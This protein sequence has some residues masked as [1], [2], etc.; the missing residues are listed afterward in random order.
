MVDLPRTCLVILWPLATLLIWMVV[1]KGL[2]RV[3]PGG[4]QVPVWCMPRSIRGQIALLS[5]V[6][7]VL[8]LLAAGLGMYLMGQGGDDLYALASGP[9]SMAV[10]RAAARQPFRGVAWPGYPHLIVALGLAELVALAAWGAWKVAGGLLRPMESV[11]AELA[12]LDFGDLPAHVPEPENA[13]EVTR[14]GD[15][16]NTCLSRLTQAKEELEEVSCR[17][18]RFASDVSHELRNPVAALRAELEDAQLDPARAR[19]PDLLRSSLRQVVRLQAIIDDL[20]WLSRVRARGSAERQRLDLAALVRTEISQ[21]ADRLPVLVDLTLGATVAAVPSQIGRLLAN[22]L[23]NAQRHSAKLVRVEVRATQA[24]VELVVSDDGPGIAAA[25]RERV[26]HRFIRLDDARRLDGDGT[27]L[28]LA[29]ARDIAHAH[30]GTLR[31]E[32]SAGGGARFV[33]RLPQ[34]RPGRAVPS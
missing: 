22:L 9:E 31:V 14:L 34:V 33:L 17:Q 18:R 1:A 10:D 13:L 25:D 11:R 2:A 5:T 23:D 21:R 26:F 32:E 4:P 19:L 20:L 28:G 8:T 24:V 27:G 7:A 15:T 30:Q 29:I 16:I 3:L 12:T 6:V